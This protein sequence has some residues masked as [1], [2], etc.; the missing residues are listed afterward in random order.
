MCTTCKRKFRN[1]TE[2]DLHTR[3]H[4]YAKLLGKNQVAKK[5]KSAVKAKVITTSGTADK[6]IIRKYLKDK[7]GIN[8]PVK[9]N[10]VKSLKSPNINLLL[11]NI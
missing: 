5:A 10:S 1:K 11:V 7:V 4:Q 2:L 8:S 6:K 3:S 9:E